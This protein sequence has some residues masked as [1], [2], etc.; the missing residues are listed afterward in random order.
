MTLRLRVRVIQHKRTL[1]I[2]WTFSLYAS[3]G[4]KTVRG[5]KV[6]RANIDFRFAADAG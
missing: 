5:G 4:D 6:F 1:P 2:E 3:R